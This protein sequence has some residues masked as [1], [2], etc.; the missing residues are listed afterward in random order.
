MFKKGLIPCLHSFADLLDNRR[1]INIGNEKIF[2][3]TVL[4]FLTYFTF[5][6]FMSSFILTYSV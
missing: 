4:F 1:E 5:V 3:F 2:Q 6:I